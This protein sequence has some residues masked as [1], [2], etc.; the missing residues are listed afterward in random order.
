LA[1]E[2]PAHRAGLKGKLSYM[3]RSRPGVSRSID[4]PTCFPGGA[5]TWEMLHRGSPVRRQ[6]APRTLTA[7]KQMPVPPPSALRP[8]I[9][10]ALDRIVLRA[11]TR[12][13]RAP[14]PERRGAGR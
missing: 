14:L 11:L 4:V 3:S 9:P 10:A 5:T 13:S 8:A 1:D 2:S 7:V 12:D 6:E